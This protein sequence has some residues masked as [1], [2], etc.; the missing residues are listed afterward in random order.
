MAT[1]PATARIASAARPPVANAVRAAWIRREL[2]VNG[3]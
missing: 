3:C 1:T 2:L